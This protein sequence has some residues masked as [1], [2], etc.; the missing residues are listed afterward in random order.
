MRVAIMQPYLF[1]YLGYYQ[2]AFS[3]DRWVFYD[4]VMYIK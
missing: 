1:P 4:D 2:L 3:V